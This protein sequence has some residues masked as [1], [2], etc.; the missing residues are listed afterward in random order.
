MV[1]GLGARDALDA[2]RLRIA[3]ASVLGRARELGRA[4]SAGSCRTRSATSDAAA[5]VEGT[6]LSAYR[7]DRYKTPSAEEHP[8]LQ[9]L[10]VAAHDDVAATVR[11][12]RSWCARRSTARATCRTRRPTT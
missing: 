7:F 10:I 4:G 2:E 3:A 11:A 5:L 8:Q 1:V 12:A 9:A 6:L